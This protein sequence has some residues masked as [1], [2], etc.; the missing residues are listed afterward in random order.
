VIEPDGRRITITYDKLLRRTAMT[1][2]AGTPD[3]ATVRFAYDGVGNLTAFTDG[4]GQTT[5]Y[6]RD[7]RD[8]L[9]SSTDPLGHTT[10]YTYD[11]AGQLLQ[12][13]DALGRITSRTYDA[14]G[15]VVAET[16]ANGETL[17]FTYDGEG[18]PLTFTDARG[19]V[20]SFAYDAAGRMSAKRY[21]DGSVESAAYNLA[22]EQ[23]TRINRA[24]QIQS[25]VYDLRSRP[26]AAT[27]SGSVA[28][29]TTRTY[30]AAGRLVKL[31]HGRSVLEYR[32]DLAGQLLSESSRLGSQ[33]ALTVDYRYDLGGRR[34]G[35]TT[36][37]GQTQAW[38]FDGRGLPTVLDVDGSNLAAFTY[39]ARGLL[40]T[41]TL[42]NGT[43][44]TYTYDAAARLQAM[45]GIVPVTY[46][47]N[48]TG[49][50]TGRHDAAFGPETFTYDAIDQVIGANYGGVRSEGFAY[51]AMGN[52]QSASDTATGITAY[53]VRAD[54]AYTS[55]GG[56]A[57]QTDLN[58][59]MVSVPGA[60]YAYDGQ[61]RLVRAEKDGVV[62]E[63]E[64]DGFNRCLERR[65]T[66]PGGGAETLR[67]VYAGWGLIEERNGEGALAAQY[68][69]GA[70]TDDIV[71]KSTV[72]GTVYY[73]RDGLGSTVALSDASGQVVERYRYDVF[74]RVEIRSATGESV[75]ESLFGNRFLFTGREHLSEAGLYDYRNRV[76]SAELGRFLQTDPIR[77]SAGDGNLY[78]YVGNDAVNLWDPWGLC[79][80]TSDSEKFNDFRQ[81]LD[82]LLS[83]GPLAAW[84]AQPFIGDTTGAW[85][86]NAGQQATRDYGNSD[87]GEAIRH[88]VW[89]AELSR[90]F[91]EKAA[92]AIGDAHERRSPDVEDSARDQ[93]NNKLGREIAKESGGRDDSLKKAKEDWE[94]GRA[95]LRKKTLGYEAF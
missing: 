24:G 49:Q 16:N 86:V 94:K 75:P 45:R 25:L 88:E 23:T 53:T 85:A 41:R 79:S 77:F 78:R 8:W 35:L 58:G 54:N 18:R 83:A 63:F 55:V 7:R 34:S 52:R 90:K 91:G 87:A 43:T 64:Y 28:P 57:T 30:D 2:G 17:A 42:E 72:A 6:T 69:H 38:Q 11:T 37:G 22:G 26:R 67:L 39:D 44:S 47:L 92:K 89:Q 61:N 10:S 73:H 66:R 76:Y 36:P 40:A 9:T 65:T 4:A 19:M 48:A 82:A 1:Q 5:R 95:A 81:I 31:E 27:W 80:E 93:F 70:Q 50:R 12:I 32:Y 15:R 51:D 68:V 33:P 84:D 20:Y 3:A 46:S 74:G 13:T 62:T 59:N 56:I 71:A 29:A 60:I 14:V 21:P